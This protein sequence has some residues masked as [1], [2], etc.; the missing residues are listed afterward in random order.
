M[1]KNYLK[2]AWRSLLRNKGLAFINIFGLA[3]GMAF[4]LFISLWIQYETSFASIANLWILLSREFVLL[5]TL[6]GLIASPLAFWLMHD[7]LQKYDYR[8]TINGWIFI[9]AGLVAVIIALFTVSTQ[10]VKAAL[11]NPVKALRKE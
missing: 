1:F 8:I 2:I 6:S 9:V 10:A 4:A 7:W 3:I 5:M 11:T